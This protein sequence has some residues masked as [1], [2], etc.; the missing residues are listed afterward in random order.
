MLLLVA[1][2]V[3]HAVATGR[4][5]RDLVVRRQQKHLNRGIQ[6]TERL[7]MAMAVQMDRARLVGKERG[8]NVACYDL[9]RNKF[10]QHQ[11]M[12]GE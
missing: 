7:I 6:R 10:I 8:V 3:R 2:R 5:H 9:G 4:D 1:E 12:R 11:A